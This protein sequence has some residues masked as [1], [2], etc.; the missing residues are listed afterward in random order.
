MVA[1]EPTVANHSEP[2]WL[3]LN[4]NRTAENTIGASWMNGMS[5]KSSQP[6][7]PRKSSRIAMAAYYGASLSRD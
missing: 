3:P 6:L 1:Y 7:E 2:S 4:L 5:L